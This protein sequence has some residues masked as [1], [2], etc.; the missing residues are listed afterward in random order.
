[1]PPVTNVPADRLDAD[2]LVGAELGAVR[3]SRSLPLTAAL[4]P[5]AALTALIGGGDLR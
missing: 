4:T 3:T 5:V 2:E 1:M